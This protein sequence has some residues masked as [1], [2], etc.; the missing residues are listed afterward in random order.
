MPGFN[1]EAQVDK[2]TATGMGLG[3]VMRS[4]GNITNKTT[5]TSSP[6]LHV[7]LRAFTFGLKTQDFRSRLVHSFD[8]DV[9]ELDVMP[10]CVGK[11]PQSNMNR[12]RLSESAH[13]LA[14]RL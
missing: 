6:G 10:E 13:K 4:P 5:C 3:T 9:P 11:K 12:L 7:G 8:F 14:S 2:V 1:D